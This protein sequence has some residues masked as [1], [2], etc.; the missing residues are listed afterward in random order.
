[1]PISYSADIPLTKLDSEIMRN[2]FRKYCG[3]DYPSS[4]C[5][6]AQ[7]TGQVH[8]KCF[9]EMREKVCGLDF[10]I[11]ES[12]NTENDEDAES[13]K[14]Q[15]W[16]SIDATQDAKGRNVAAFVIGSLK[17]PEYGAFLTNLKNFGDESVTA[18]KYA[19]FFKESLKQLYPTGK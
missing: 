6:R 5:L 7:R 4:G 16:A 8:A 18:E 2:F 14:E 3:R 9:L 19:D 1:M 10:Q 12:G 15:I 13:D 17:H 11:N